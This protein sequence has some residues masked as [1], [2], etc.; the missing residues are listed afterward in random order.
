M[1]TTYVRWGEEFDVEISRDDDAD[2]PWVRDEFETEDSERSQRWKQ[3][4]WEYVGI[5]VTH[6]SG[7]QASLWGIESDCEEYIQETI[8]DLMIEA[9]PLTRFGREVYEAAHAVE[10]MKG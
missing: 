7:T 5:I 8:Q 3:D 9:C 2:A 10:L 4:L 6:S 1:G